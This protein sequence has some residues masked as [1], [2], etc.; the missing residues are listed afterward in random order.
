[1]ARPNSIRV[2]V[3]GGDEHGVIIA[4][5]CS[6]TVILPKGTFMINDSEK[7]NICMDSVI[8]SCFN[9]V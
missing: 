5:T 6:S 9:M 4:Q 8:S 1:M 2:M 7:F 3:D